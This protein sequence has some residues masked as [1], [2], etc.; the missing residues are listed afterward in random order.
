MLL[1]INDEIKEKSLKQFFIISSSNIEEEE[2]VR[3]RIELNIHEKVF[4]FLQHTRNTSCSSFFCFLKRKTS[5]YK[6]LSQKTQFLIS[7]LLVYFFF[8]CR[9]MSNTLRLLFF[10]RLAVSRVTKILRRQ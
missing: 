3:Q 2:D 7:F 5:F 10:F 9:T 6:N 4:L 1:L 8:S